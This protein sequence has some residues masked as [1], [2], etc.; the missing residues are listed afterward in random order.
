M[1]GQCKPSEG[2]WEYGDTMDGCCWGAC[3][4]NGCHESHPTGVYQIAGPEFRSGDLDVY[5]VCVR[6]E[7]D[8][9]LICEAGTVYHETKLTPRQLLAQRD[10]LLAALKLV[11]AELQSMVPATPNMEENPIWQKIFIG[12]TAIAN[13]EKGEK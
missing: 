1:T 4:V 5:G 3:T 7:S 9:A 2:P 6:N 8:A 10:E 11:T 12:N 13:A